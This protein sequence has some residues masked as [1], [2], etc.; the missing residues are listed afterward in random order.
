MQMHVLLIRK[1]LKL[2]FRSINFLAFTKRNA[3]HGYQL[4]NCP[5][6]HHF[7][8][9]L[10]TSKSFFL[11]IDGMG[12]FLA[13]WLILLGVEWLTF[14]IHM[15]YLELIINTIR[16]HRGKKER[17]R[18]R[19]GEKRK[20][21]DYQFEL[22]FFFCPHISLPMSRQHNTEVCLISWVKVHALAGFL[23]HAEVRSWFASA[24][25]SVFSCHH[26]PLSSLV[27]IKMKSGHLTVFSMACS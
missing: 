27:S 17:E 3:S 22:Y 15:A 6:S 7:F 2:N 10:L 26:Y 13:Q 23:L 4:C 24:L 11:N 19:N 20:K 21:C 8:P 1:R 12:M 5:V 9:T 16:N 18:K 14:Q 25:T